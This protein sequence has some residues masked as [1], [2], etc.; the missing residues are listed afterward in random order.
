MILIWFRYELPVWNIREAA[1]YLRIDRN[2]MRKSVMFERRKIRMLMRGIKVGKQQGGEK[3]SL[4]NLFI[5][6]G[7]IDPKVKNY[8]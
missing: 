4:V 7:F 6:K 5:E 1:P 8:L 2:P 3:V